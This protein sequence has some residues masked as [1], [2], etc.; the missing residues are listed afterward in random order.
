MHTRTVQI[1][2]A[3][4]NRWDLPHLGDV[5]QTPFAD[6]EKSHR[7]FAI[8]HPYQKWGKKG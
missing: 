1:W 4:G 5:C 3:T 8:I 2:D 7:G 6:L